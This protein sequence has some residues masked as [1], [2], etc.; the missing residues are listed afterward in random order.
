MVKE[1]QAACFL[2]VVGLS[3]AAEAAP[4]RVHV[5]PA[6]A[7]A[8]APAAPEPAWTLE[9]IKEGYTL[10]YGLPKGDPTIAFAC[11][12]RSGDVTIHVPEASGKATIDQ[13]QSV[14][15]TVGGVRS[16]FAGQVV[17]DV[18]SGGAMLSVTVPARNPMFTA[19]AGP[20]GLRIEGK[21]FTKIVPLK[22]I[23]EKLKQFLGTCRKG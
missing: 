18:V 10:Y 23:G 19:L 15:L 16:S 7:L 14:S 22:A 6:P 4:A 2:S 11:A 20:G 17:D 13:S 9:K 3:G 12:P 1:L 21:G 8:A 5:H